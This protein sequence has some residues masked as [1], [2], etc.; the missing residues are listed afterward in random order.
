MNKDQSEKDGSPS[1]QLRLNR[2]DEK[3]TVAPS[4]SLFHWLGSLA[5]EDDH[6]IQH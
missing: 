6:A 1:D 4:H 3:K 5:Q 2:T